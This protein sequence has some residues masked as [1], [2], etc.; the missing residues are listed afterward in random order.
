MR[1]EGQAIKIANRNGITRRHSVN[2]RRRP[3]LRA[4]AA[5]RYWLLRETKGRDGR[6]LKDLK[7]QE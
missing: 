5:T 3:R 6:L 7:W 1:S 2:A 4:L